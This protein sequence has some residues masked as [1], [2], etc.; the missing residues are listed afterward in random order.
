LLIGAHRS[1]APD[2]DER[3][4][5]S[6]SGGMTKRSASLAMNLSVQQPMC[7]RCG[8]HLP[9]RARF[10]TGCGT[11]VQPTYVAWLPKLEAHF[12]PASKVFTSVG[13]L[14][15]IVWPAVM[16]SPF[17]VP[18]EHREFGLLLTFACALGGLAL[19]LG[20]RLKMGGRVEREATR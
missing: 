11:R 13:V 20:L 15:L 12:A 17:Y 19:P 2:S 9:V 10:C 3:G 4:R 16:A 14:S 7:R 6:S 5:D 1:Q 8:Q 18:G